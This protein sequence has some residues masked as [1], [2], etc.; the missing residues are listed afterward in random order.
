MRRWQSIAVGTSFLG[1]VVMPA[2]VGWFIWQK[3]PPP[4]DVNRFAAAF[5]DIVGPL[6]AALA[7]AGLIYTAP[8]Q[9]EELALQ[10]E[11][12]RETRIELRRTADAQEASEAALQAQVDTARVAAKLNAL[13]S[14]L[15][16]IE[17]DPDLVPHLPTTGKQIRD[18]EAAERAQPLKQQ[19]KD[20]IAELEG[21]SESS[22]S[23]GGHNVEKVS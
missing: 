8:M 13:A 23:S 18:I 1:V 9:R 3:L 10:R 15:D 19:I 14:L 2:A 12:L 22:S 4:K 21:L 7:F 11:E 20:A 5:G 16:N 6:F 17:R